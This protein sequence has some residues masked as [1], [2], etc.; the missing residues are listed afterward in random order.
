MKN[1]LIFRTDRIGDFLLTAIL[2]RAIKRNDPNSFIQVIGSNK[3]YNY[4]KSFNSV[5]EVFLLKKGF[6]NRLRLLLLLKKKTY[7]NI[8]VHDAFLPSATPPHCTPCTSYGGSTH[9]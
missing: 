5:N 3:N 1:Y 2:I 7:Q 6:F 8:I 4:I 9:I